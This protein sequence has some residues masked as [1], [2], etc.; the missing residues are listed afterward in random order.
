MNIKDINSKKSYDFSC[1]YLWTNLVNGKHYVGQTQ[2]FYSRMCQYNKTH[3]NK[4]LK[5]AISKYT[6]ENFEI[7][8][9]EKTDIELLYMGNKTFRIFFVGKKSSKMFLNE[10]FI[11]TG[12]KLISKNEDNNSKNN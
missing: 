6:L 2:N 12:V 10:Q 7:E 1:I 3:G 8:V 9:L 5:N 11:K 4:Y